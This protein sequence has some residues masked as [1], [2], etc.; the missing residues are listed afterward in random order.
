MTIMPKG[1]RRAS[2]ACLRRS[3]SRA[4]MPSAREC[5]STSM[6]RKDRKSTRLNSSHLGIS[7]AVFCL[8]K[9]KKQKN[10]DNHNAKEDHG[11]LQTTTTR[12]KYDTPQKP[13]MH[14]RRLRRHSKGS[15]RQQHQSISDR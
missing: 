1:M 14:Y 15:S 13:D 12:N 3:M 11:T 6:C 8:K 5:Q 4:K 9:K 2:Q 7:Y 10:R